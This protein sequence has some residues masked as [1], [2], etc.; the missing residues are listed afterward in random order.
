MKNV[1]DGE[2]IVVMI[3]NEVVFVMSMKMICRGFEVG[4]IFLGVCLKGEMKDIGKGVV[5]EIIE[6]CSLVI[7][8]EGDWIYFG[9]IYLISK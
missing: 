1:C 4:V 7:G 3:I 9:K 5:K 6:R 8:I 2:M